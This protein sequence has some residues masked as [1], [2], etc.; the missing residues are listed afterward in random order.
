VRL[1]RE[2]PRWGYRRIVGELVGLGSSVS[3]SSVRKILAGAGLGPTGTRSGLS[4]SQFVRAQ[5]ESMIACDFF[6][7][8]TIALR[9]LYVLSFIEVSSRRV[10]LGGISGNPD[11]PTQQ[12]AFT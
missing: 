8:D 11:A 5:A 3:T 12:T 9:R 1:A 4:W 6:T 7:V 10:H 2:N